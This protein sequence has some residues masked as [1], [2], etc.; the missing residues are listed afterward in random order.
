MVFLASDVV[1]DA[2][3]A[4]AKAMSPMAACA[5]T[6][7]D[8]PLPLAGADS[9]DIPDNL[10]P[11][12]ARQGHGQ[13]ACGDRLVAGTQRRRQQML[14]PPRKRGVREDVRSAHTACEHFDDEV[15]LG[16]VFPRYGD[17]G[18]DLAALGEGPGSEGGGVVGRAYWH[19]GGVVYGWRPVH[20]VRFI[21][22]PRDTLSGAAYARSRRWAK[23]TTS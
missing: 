19:V 3:A 2:A 1:T 16:G 14:A 10:V 17:F 15:A 18:E 7:A 6:V 13:R 11:R 9:D 8:A 21:C 4:A 5:D 12:D 22:A 23:R 20:P